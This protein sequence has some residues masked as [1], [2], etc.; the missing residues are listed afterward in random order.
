[1]ETTKPF[2]KWAGGKT[3]I[4]E[5]VLG[6]FPSQIGNYYE[7]FLGGGSVLLG[8][9]TQRAA[10][11]IRITGTV[12]ASDVNSNLIGLYQ[13]LQGSLE[14]LIVAIKKLIEEFGKCRKEAVNRKA[15]TLEEAL[16]SPESY[17]FWIRSEFNQMGK[18]V[19]TSLRGSALFLFLNKTCWRGLYRENQSG[20]FNVPYGNYANPSIM[21]EAHLRA[22]S[23]LIQGVVFKEA[24]FEEALA[25]V[26]AG[27]FMYTDPPY[28]PVADTSFVAYT[29]GGFDGAA[30]KRLF[31]LC[32]G[33]KEK[34]VKFLMSNAEA[35]LVTDAFLLPL[36]KTK[37][38][39]CKRSINSKKPGAKA[40]EVL[41]TN[42]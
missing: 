25:G 15:A 5:E 42:W 24:R 1:M 31:E 12:Y 28:V 41:I 21:D 10:G 3:Q 4:L 22:I 9:L 40:N 7:P 11:K 20:G 30:H 2:L 29:D 8:L 36:Y 13:N 26:V 39:S 23:A 37:I 27:D 38:I 34:G 16:G 14:P 18:E 32:G 33:M 6:L 35:K 19:R 17:Y